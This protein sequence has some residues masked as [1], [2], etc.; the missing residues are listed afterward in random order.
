M[1]KMVGVSLSL[2]LGDILNGK[3]ALEDVALIR[4]STAARDEHDWNRLATMY[5]RD[6]WKA[7][8]QLVNQT[9]Q[10]LRDSDRIDQPRLRGEDDGM[11]LRVPNG[12]YTLGHYTALVMAN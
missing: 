3:I 6:Y 11:Y 12:W 8:Q 5:N 7:D 1:T 2:C 9:I 10:I 4:A